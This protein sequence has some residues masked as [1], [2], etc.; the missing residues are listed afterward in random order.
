MTTHLESY[1][2]NDWTQ[3]VA[4][5]GVRK[6]GRVHSNTEVERE[7]G[8]TDDAAKVD[9]L[10]CLRRAYEHFRSMTERV[11]VVKDRSSLTRNTDTYLIR[12]TRQIYWKEKP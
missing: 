4:F 6:R 9:C 1:W 7:A 5:C 8:I 11:A 12:W 3:C 10:V 2:E